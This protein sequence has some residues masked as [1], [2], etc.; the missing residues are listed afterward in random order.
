MTDTAPAPINT[1]I[2]ICSITQDRLGRAAFAERV[3]ERIAAAGTG[4]SVVFGLAGPWGAGKTSILKMI[5]Q[6]MKTKYPHTWSVVWFTPWSADNVQALTDE[7][8]NSIA[9]AMP[10]TEPGK[11]AARKVLAMAPAAIAVTKA[12]GRAFVDKHIGQDASKAMAEAL[13]DS[14]AEAAG[15][16]RIKED[17]FVTKFEK[18]CEAIDEVGRNVLVVVDDIDRLHADE[19]LTVLKAVRLLGRFDRVHYLLSYDEHTVLDVLQ[20]SDIANNDRNRAQAYLEKIIQYPVMLPPL[21]EPQLHLELEDC[22]SQVARIHNLQLATVNDYRGGDPVDT[23]ICAIPV[24]H[25]G[26]LTLRSIR[27]LASQIDVLFTLVGADELNFVDAALVTYLRLHHRELYDVLPLWLNELTGV[28][29]VSFDGSRDKSKE[30]WVTLVAETT[31][32][33]PVRQPLARELLDLLAT[34]FPRIPRRSIPEGAGQLGIFRSDYFARYFAFGMPASDVSDRAVRAEWATLCTS[35]ALPPDSVIGASF[36]RYAQNTLV[37][38]KVRHLENDI[39]LAP[40]Q[41]ALQA[42]LNVGRYACVHGHWLS[43]WAPLVF[44]FVRRAVMA[45]A[46]RPAAMGYIDSFAREFGLPLAAIILRR[47]LEE[48]SEITESIVAA[49]SNFR[50]SVVLACQQDLTMDVLAQTPSAPMVRDFVDYLDSGLWEQLRV[51]ASHLVAEGARTVCELAGRFVMY[52]PEGSRFDDGEEYL[53]HDG[54]FSQVVPAE[55]WTVPKTQAEILGAGPIAGD[56]TLADR[57]RFAT[58][59]LWEMQQRVQD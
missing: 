45:A 44:A 8:Y 39:E 12:A 29:V 10:D 18:V 51:L 5:E 49:S 53:F 17:P 43:G 52:V 20:G 2:A 55:Q 11:T 27:R 50:A 37:L 15:K 32:L 22:L 30:E 35:G 54:A 42:A 21:Q 33:D 56:D 23:I 1:D 14:V 57:I 34:L 38:R 36:G 28:P 48:S 25:R 16:F 40:A 6:L 19:L 31:G 46:T 24:S 4:P 58:Q 47:A 59:R 3:S 26:R 7:F 13:V 9:A 41:I